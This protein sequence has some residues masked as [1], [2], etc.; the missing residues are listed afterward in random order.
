MAEL[1]REAFAAEA[2]EE[3][4]LPGWEFCE[5]I[6]GCGCKELIGEDL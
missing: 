6:A 5:K 2:G 3:A 4:R 1:G